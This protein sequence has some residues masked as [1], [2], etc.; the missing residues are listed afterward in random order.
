MKELAQIGIGSTQQILFLNL[1]GEAKKVPQKRYK[2]RACFGTW[3]IEWIW[4]FY[5]RWV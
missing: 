1:I 3:T 5:K 4:A 2:I